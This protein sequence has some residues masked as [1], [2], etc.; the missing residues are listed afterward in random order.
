[1]GSA[2]RGKHKQKETAEARPLSD[3]RLANPVSI[4]IWAIVFAAVSAVA[5]LMANRRMPDL[6][7]LAFLCAGLLVAFY[8][9]FALKIAQQWE[10][11]IVLRLG[12]FQRLTG[13]G[14]FWILPIVDNAPA[15]SITASWSRHLTPNA[16]SPRTRSR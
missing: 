8:F 15:G 13:P 7:I 9:L 2:I 6:W 14:L 12:K 1:M 10:K 5:A 11:A 3:M 4:T 16:P